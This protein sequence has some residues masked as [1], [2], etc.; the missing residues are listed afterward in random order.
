MERMNLGRRY[1]EATLESV[2]D[3]T[4]RRVVEKY[5]DEFPQMEKQG[6]GVYLWGANSVGKTYLAS[7][8]LK[9]LLKRNKL[10]YVITA[11]VL[12]SIYIDGKRFD[13]N[14]T[15]VQRVES[16]PVL[17]IEDVGKEYSGKGSGWAELNFENLLRHRSRNLLITWMT[18]N[19]SPAQLL[20][21]YKQSA[22]ALMLESMLAVEV[23]GKDWRKEIA[24]G[25]VSWVRD[26]E[27]KD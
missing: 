17:L 10:S 8:V 2:P 24:R 13:G 18:S 20:D 26:E 12:K 27:D 19:L 7:A 14:Q 1:Y 9:E 21:R 22:M 4:H 6:I 16:I 23:Q 25:L 15:V 3:S 11:D 5:L